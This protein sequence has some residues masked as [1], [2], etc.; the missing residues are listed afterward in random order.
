MNSFI[1]EFKEFALK[2][3]MMELA[4]GIVIGTAFNAVVDSL[5]KDVILQAIAML[6]GQPDFSTITIGAIKIGSF[7]NN[8][9]HFLIIA[10][11]VF[12]VIKAMN[13]V[14]KNK[15]ALSEAKNN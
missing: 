14:L 15:E 8:L 2:G 5:V 7:I 1:K 12:V 3:N 4:I 13:K 6:F 9:V 11:S 10:L